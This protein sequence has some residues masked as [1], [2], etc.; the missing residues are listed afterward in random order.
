MLFDFGVGITL[1]IIGLL[2]VPFPMLISGY[3]ILPKEK[4]EKV[5]IKGLSHLIRSW[6]VGMGVSLIIGSVLLELFGLQ[7]IKGTF[8]GILLLGGCFLLLIKTNRYIP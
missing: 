5:D 2:A 7:E 1:I 3:N 4:K 8:I 6:L